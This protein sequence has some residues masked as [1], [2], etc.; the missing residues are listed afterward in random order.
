MHDKDIVGI[1]VQREHTAIQL[2]YRAFPFVAGRLFYFAFN[3]ILM[4]VFNR[5]NS[6]I[7]Y[8]VYLKDKIHHRFDRKNVQCKLL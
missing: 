8:N 2:L 1:V 5:L 3:D 4:V 6:I 7:K